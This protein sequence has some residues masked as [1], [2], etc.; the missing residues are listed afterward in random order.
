M[1]KVAAKANRTLGFIRR[2]VTTS[3]TEAKVVTYKSLVWPQMEYD[4]CII[5]PYTELQIT[6]LER[7]EYCTAWWVT[8]EN[9]RMGSVTEM[10]AKLT[11]ETLEI[12]RSKIRL[13]MFY[14][15]LNNLIA[16]QT[17]HSLRCNTSMTAYCMKPNTRDFPG[18]KGRLVMRSSGW[19]W[20]GWGMS[21]RDRIVSLII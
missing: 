13:A 15:I 3:S 1:E 7:V 5:D 11:W 21:H 18:R 17:T 6:K 19:L 14:I 4:F 8:G 2:T 9:Q 10:M 16:I 20:R 12:G